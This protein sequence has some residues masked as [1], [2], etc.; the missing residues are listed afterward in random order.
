MSSVYKTYYDLSKI[1]LWGDNPN[2][3][4]KKARLTFGFR[5][6]NPRV[7]V[8]TGVPGKEGFIP[9][10]ADL[11]HMT[12][13]MNYLKE[14]AVG[15]PDHQVNIDSLANVYENNKP[16]NNKRVVSTLTIGKSKEGIV[17]IAV[18]AEGKPKIVFPIKQSDYHVFKDKNKNIIPD[19]EVS[20]RM[21]LSVADTILN[22]ITDVMLRYTEEEYNTS[23]RKP[24]PIAEGNG[25][26]T[27]GTGKKQ[28]SN[29]DQFDDL[30][31]LVL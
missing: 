9:F 1:V 16:T 13:A 17:Y 4:T 25:A 24:V 11:P 5:D 14:I 23:E 29:K 12:T 30:D 8:N 2:D 6:G 15:E 27:K 28:E 7:T 19:S 3:N 21:A 31:E 10:P 18:T 26:N 22:S 20:K